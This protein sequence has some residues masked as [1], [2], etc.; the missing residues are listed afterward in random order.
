MPTVLAP[1]AWEARFRSLRSTRSFFPVTS[2]RNSRPRISACSTAFTQSRLVHPSRWSIFAGAATSVVDYLDGFEQSGNWNR[3]SRA[4]SPLTSKNRRLT[5]GSSLPATASMLSAV[6][7]EADIVWPSCCRTISASSSSASDRAFENLQNA[8]RPLPGFHSDHDEKN[9]NAHLQS[10][11]IADATPR[12]TIGGDLGPG[13]P[14][15]SHKRVRSVGCDDQPPVNEVSVR[16]LDSSFE[17]FAPAVKKAAPA[18]VRIITAVRPESLP[19]LAGRNESPFSTS[20]SGQL[21]RVRPG[22]LV[23]CGLG[24]GVIVTEDGY[25]LTNNHLVDGPKEVEVTLQDGREF[26]AKVI[27]LDPRS[28]IAVIKIDAQH[29]PTVSLADSRDVQVGDV[30]LAIGNPFGVGQTVTHGIVSATD[31]GGIGIED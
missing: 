9:E 14:T 6:T 27:G 29:L 23:E 1:I 21:P 4:A 26:K 20:F 24:S 22:H 31:R 28:D 8:P 7:D 5:G 18:V 16:P 30:V 3:A 15:G 25:I 13:D 17:T 19:K 10:A 11:I 2:T 12:R